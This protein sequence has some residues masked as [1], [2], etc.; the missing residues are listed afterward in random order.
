MVNPMRL[1]IPVKVG[2]QYG[3]FLFELAQVRRGSNATN[4][5]I[6]A[7]RNRRL[8]YD[9]VPLGLIVSLTNAVVL[10]KDMVDVDFLV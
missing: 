10:R 9:A 3:A 2:R 1:H 5:A 6:A 7:C 4:L 8:V